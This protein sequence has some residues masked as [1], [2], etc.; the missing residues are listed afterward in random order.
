MNDADAIRNLVASYSLEADARNVAAWA[1][2]FADDGALILNGTVQGQGPADLHD[3]FAGRSMP[4]GYHMVANLRLDIQSDEATGVANF[5]SVGVDN[6][7]GARGMY[8]AV[9]VKRGNDW[10]IAE[11][12]IEVA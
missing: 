7:V 2:L 11:W 8:R 9:F 3:W 5:I 10:K 6:K 4:A 12:R 1:A